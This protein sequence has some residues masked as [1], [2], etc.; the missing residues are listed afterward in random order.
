MCN[1]GAVAGGANIWS[2]N[3]PFIDH[4]ETKAITAALGFFHWS[5]ALYSSS[6]H[7]TEADVEHFSDYP[8]RVWGGHATI[9]HV[10]SSPIKDDKAELGPR[11]SV[12]GCGFRWEKN[13]FILCEPS[14]KKC[15]ALQITSEAAPMWGFNGAM[16]R[17]LSPS[18]AWVHVG[19]SVPS[20][21]TGSSFDGSVWALTN[22]GS[23]PTWHQLQGSIP[24]EGN[25]VI[26]NGRIVSVDQNGV[27]SMQLK[28]N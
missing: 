18:G 23:N 1:I 26:G 24:S 17:Y 2:G 11:L 14:Q 10:L 9:C 25:V 22:L 19:G 16:N 4:N 12:H 7:T 13:R 5:I 21:M 20:G 6:F 8:G 3:R 15:T 27:H 28:E